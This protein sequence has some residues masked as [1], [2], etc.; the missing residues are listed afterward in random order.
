MQ[1]EK[2]TKAQLIEDLTRLRQHSMILERHAAECTQALADT[3]AGLTEARAQQAATS[4]ILRLIASSPTDV[5]PVFDAIAASA[6]TLCEAQ[7]GSVYR[8]D[9]RLIHLVAHHNH[10]PDALEAIRRAFPM[11]PGRGSVTARA[12]LTRAVAHVPD[13]AA[14]PEYLHCSRLQSGLPPV[15]AVPVLR[16]GTP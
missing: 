7:N 12:I 5:Q 9:G 10:S 4:D 14:D 6:A 11:P 16:S 15:L 3:R 2:K 8:F 13:A 1:D